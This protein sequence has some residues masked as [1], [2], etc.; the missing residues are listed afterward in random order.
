MTTSVGDDYLPTNAT[1]GAIPVGGLATGKVQYDGD[2]D[3]FR[4]V[5]DKDV[6]YTLTLNAAPYLY[7]LSLYDAAVKLIDSYGGNTNAGS[8][9]MVVHAPEAGEYCLDVT[10]G[11]IGSLPTQQAYSVGLL[12][13]GR[14]LVG[15]TPATAQGATIG[16]PMRGARRSGRRGRLPHGLHG[17]RALC[18]VAPFRQWRVGAD[19]LARARA[20]WPAAVIRH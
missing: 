9:R 19:L 4:L 18:A 1:H 14:D 2:V 6:S 10:H 13:G 5:L 17:R 3:R 8:M 15:D 11:A 7:N 12:A 16:T 20:R